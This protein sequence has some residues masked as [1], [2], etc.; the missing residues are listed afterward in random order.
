MLTL[1]YYTYYTYFT[2]YTY[3]TL[4]TRPK[5]ILFSKW[6]RKEARP[7]DKA[8]W[9]GTSTSTS[10]VPRASC[11]GLASWLVALVL[12]LVVGGSCWWLVLV[13][14]AL[15]LVLGAWCL[16]SCLVAGG[17]WLVPCA[18]CLVAGGLCLVPVA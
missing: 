13:P 15:C 9:P 16:V 10:T 6:L 3:Y 7:R 14:G 11:L 2:Y 1:L 8:S 12:G 18:W 17:W 5:T 4:L